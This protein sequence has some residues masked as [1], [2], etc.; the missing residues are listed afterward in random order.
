MIEIEPIVTEVVPH[1]PPQIIIGDQVKDTEMEE[2]LK[3]ADDNV[4]I[5]LLS[6]QHEYAYSNPTHFFN[7]SKPD[8]PYRS[9][10]NYGGYSEITYQGFKAN[11]RTTKIEEQNK[12]AAEAE[13]A[14]QEFTKAEIPQN[15]K[16]TD[17]RKW[18]EHHMEGAIMLRLEVTNK[19]NTRCQVEANI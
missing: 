1:F 9:S 12:L 7:L 14:K 11:E 4:E 15:F 8:C 16:E 13:E 10:A 18:E 5:R 2:I 6:S 3:V 19:L 17:V